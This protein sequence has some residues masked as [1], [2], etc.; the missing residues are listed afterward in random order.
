LGLSAN[1]SQHWERLSG[2]LLIAFLA[3][4]VLRLIGE[5]A[6][7]RQMERMGQSNTHRS[8]PVL[9]LVSLARQLVRKEIFDFSRFAYL[10]AL[11]RLQNRFLLQSV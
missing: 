5:I 11:K 1:R 8:R 9:S 4:F 10:A 2:L 3:S 6:H 7:S